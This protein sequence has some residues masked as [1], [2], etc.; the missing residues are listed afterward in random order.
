MGE[1]TGLCYGVQALG[2]KTIGS[3]WVRRGGGA[4]DR[5]LNRCLEWAAE[6]LD[7]GG[8]VGLRGQKLVRSS[9]NPGTLLP[10]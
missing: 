7:G 3:C 5:N 9:R 4:G 10:S 6:R 2:T 8:V 1:H